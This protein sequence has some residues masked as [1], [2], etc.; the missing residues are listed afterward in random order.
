M[1]TPRPWVRTYADDSLVHLLSVERDAVGL[2]QCGCGE[3][4]TLAPQ[5]SAARGWVVGMPVRF[6]SGHN[7]RID[8]IARFMAQVHEEPNSGCHLWAGCVGS[9]GYGEI[10]VGGKAVLAHRFAWRLAGR[11]IPG[12]LFLLH[13]CDVRACV[14]V[15]HLRVGTNAENVADMVRRDRAVK[16]RQGLPFGVR[17]CRRRFAVQVRVA[18]RPVHLGCFATLEQAASVAA[19]ARRNRG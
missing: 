5:T 1:L 14:N 11:E 19:A 9:H 10:S 7:G 17:R 4:T 12:G 3:P 15:D 8:P 18:G 13:S 6:V 2:C 16:S